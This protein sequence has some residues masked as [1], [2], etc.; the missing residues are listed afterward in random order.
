LLPRI[1]HSHHVIGSKPSDRAKRR[2]AQE[3]AVEN[4]AKVE[5]RPA[6]F[7]LAWGASPTAQLVLASRT[8]SKTDGTAP[9]AETVVG[10]RARTNLQERDLLGARDGD[11]APRP[12]GGGILLKV[13]Q[14][15]WDVRFLF[16]LVSAVFLSSS[17]TPPAQ[18]RKLSSDEADAH[19]PIENGLR[20][21]MSQIH[22][23]QV[24]VS[25][26]LLPFSIK[27]APSWCAPYCAPPFAAC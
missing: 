2:Q 10:R 22:H 21:R 19:S 27:P 14:D 20:L 1:L 24:R 23:M 13:G 26:R 4:L 25:V 12:P 9:F 16:C 3:M 18:R 17:R 5:V 11:G 15:S 7:R 8:V 6:A